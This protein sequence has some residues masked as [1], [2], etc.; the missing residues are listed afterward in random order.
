M[1]PALASGP[2][3]FGDSAG[4][5]D[6]PVN[7]LTGFLEGF[8]QAAAL[9]RT[10]GPAECENLFKRARDAHLLLHAQEKLPQGPRDCQPGPASS[11]LAAQSDAGRADGRKAK[12]IAYVH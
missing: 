12:N 6:P 8:L 1:N 9:T 5:V 11:I 10:V 4:E 2:R 7:Y 3:G